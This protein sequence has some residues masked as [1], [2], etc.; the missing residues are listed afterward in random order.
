LGP[1]VGKAVVNVAVPL[2]RV[3]WPSVAVPEMKV[4]APDGLMPVMEAVR[5][6][7]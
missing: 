4:T 7:C 5:V 3:A 2:K 6:S 1:G